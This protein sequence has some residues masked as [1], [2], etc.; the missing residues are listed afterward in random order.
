VTLQ[1]ALLDGAVFLRFFTQFTQSTSI[2]ALLTLLS[3]TTSYFC[4]IVHTHSSH[5]LTYTLSNYTHV[6]YFSLTFPS[7]SLPHP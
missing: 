6:H 1:S 2:W 7:I 3:A 4:T 5:I